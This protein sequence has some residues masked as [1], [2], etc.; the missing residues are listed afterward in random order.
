MD[1]R[2]HDRSHDSA[3]GGGSTREGRQR[4]H[5]VRVGLLAD[6]GVS[7][8]LAAALVPGLP[9]VLAAEVDDATEWVVSTET[10]EIPLND[11]GLVPVESLAQEHRTRQGWDVMIVL[12]DLPRRIGTRPVATVLIARAHS[13]M[14]SLPGL[15]ALGV[16]R[17]ARQAT[18]HLVRAL[19]GHECGSRGDAHQA[20]RGSARC[21]T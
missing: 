11:Q 9:G 12:T 2:A 19:T 15:G 16:R 20:S 14:V 6:P 1:D 13:G 10:R 3:G 21:A 17:R 7:T 4:G 8:D 5:R 18:V